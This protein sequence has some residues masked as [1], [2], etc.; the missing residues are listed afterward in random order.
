VSER[1]GDEPVRLAVVFVDEGEDHVKGVGFV[2]EFVLEDL[3][4]VDVVGVRGRLEGF[5]DVELWR[6]GR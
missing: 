3:G 1:K 6:V 5:D 2:V 4:N